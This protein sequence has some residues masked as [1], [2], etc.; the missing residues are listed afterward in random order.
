M[1]FLPKEKIGKFISKS[2]DRDGIRLMEIG[3]NQRGMEAMSE[4]GENLTFVT[5][6]RKFISR[7]MV[8]IWLTFYSGLILSTLASLVIFSKH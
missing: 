5:T 2:E 8:F 4:T 1:T 6:S 3:K 7:E